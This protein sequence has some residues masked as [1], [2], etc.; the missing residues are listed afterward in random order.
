MSSLTDQLCIISSSKLQRFFKDL[1]TH[2]KRA[3]REKLTI[4]A[5][6]IFRKILGTFFLGFFRPEDTLTPGLT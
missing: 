3:V 4:E 2:I 6:V 1:S 5:R